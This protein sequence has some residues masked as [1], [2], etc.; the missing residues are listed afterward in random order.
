MNRSKKLITLLLA[1]MMAASVVSCAASD[2]TSDSASSDSS[3]STDTSSDSSNDDPIVITQWFWDS[4][5]F[6]DVHDEYAVVT[7]GAIVIE[8]VTVA[9]DDYLTKIQQAYASGG[10]LPD[11]LMGEMSW[12]YSAFALGIWENLEADPY[13]YD[14]SVTFDSVTSVTS[15]ADGEI[16]ALENSQNV[17]VMA[18]KKDLASEYLGTTD[19]DE[20][21]AMFQTYDDYVTVGNAVYEASGGTVTLFSG[22]Q[23]VSTMMLNQSRDICNLNDAGE[24]DVSEKINEIIDTMDA[25]RSSN[26]CGNLTCWSAEWCAAYASSDNILFPCA[27]W[28]VE[29][30]IEPNDPDGTDNWGMFTPAGGGYGWGGTCY[31]ICTTSDLKEEAWDY[32]SWQLLSDEGAEVYKESVGVFLPVTSFYEDASYTEGTNYLFGDQQIYTFMMEEVGPTVESASLTVYDSMVSDSL[33]MIA[34][35]MT[36]DASVTAEDAKALFLEDLAAKVP[37]ITV[38]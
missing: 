24:L 38:K 31:G 6:A 28:S 5:Q 11:V 27:D 19:V 8:E 30:V 7:D 15:N 12:R 16:V 34:E 21:E 13:N 10:D 26:A 22:L 29:Y 17:A 25:L 3:S 9:A 18:Y 20:L 37:D 4:S 1:G 36:A 14:R 23:D 33:N 32:I 35:L 2:D